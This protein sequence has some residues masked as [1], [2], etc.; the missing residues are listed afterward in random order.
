M[1]SSRMRHTHRGT[2]EFV[3]QSPITKPLNKWREACLILQ[4]RI[5]SHQTKNSHLDRAD[6]VWHFCV[7]DCEMAW[8]FLS[9]YAVSTGTSF[10]IAC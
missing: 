10:I 3:L 9:I 7:I 5:F 4:L 2:T 6:S 8:V 1:I